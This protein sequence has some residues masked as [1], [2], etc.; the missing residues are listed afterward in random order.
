VIERERNENVFEI[1]HNLLFR[2]TVRFLDNFST[3]TRGSKI[4]ESF[5][6]DEKQRYAVIYMHRDT[7]R[8]PFLPANAAETL[9]LLRDSD[10]AADHVRHYNTIATHLHCIEFRTIQQYLTLLYRVSSALHEVCGVNRAM[11]IL[12][13]AVSDFYIENP[14]GKN[15]ILLV[16]LFLLYVMTENKQ[17]IKFNLKVNLIS[18]WMLFLKCCGM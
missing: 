11:L 8:Q 16:L 7:A 18:Q 10:A 17:N 12:A 9:A 14:T 15:R 4:A 6:N 3:G 5:L 2:N 1:L 13:A